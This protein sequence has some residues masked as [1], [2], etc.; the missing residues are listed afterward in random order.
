MAFCTTGIKSDVFRL[1]CA[2]CN[3]MIRGHL[4]FTLNK[5]KSSVILILFILSA[6]TSSASRVLRVAGAPKVT[7]AVGLMIFISSLR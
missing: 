5:P 1:C 2:Q 3:D 6:E 4:V 7:T